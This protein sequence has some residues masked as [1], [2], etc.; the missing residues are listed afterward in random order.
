MEVKTRKGNNWDDDG[1]LAISTS[2]QVK[3]WRTAEV[4][5]TEYPELADV[6]CRFDVALLTYRRDRQ[7]PSETQISKANK[8]IAKPI[9]WEAGYKL[10]L[11]Q[12]IESAF[13]EVI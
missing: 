13:D 2:K 4:F 6:P 8:R 3:I 10:I 1:L 12:Y 5:L 11:Q 7:S 9:F